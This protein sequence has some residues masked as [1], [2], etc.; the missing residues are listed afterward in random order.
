M[1]SEQVEIE[2]NLSKKRYTFHCNRWLGKG[3]DDGQCVR[4]LPASGDDIKTPLEGN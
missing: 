2:N 4:E 3:E 1:F